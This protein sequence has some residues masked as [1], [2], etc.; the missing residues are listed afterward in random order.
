MDR[1]EGAVVEARER[2][3]GARPLHAPPR[4]GP[5]GIEAQEPVV[6]L[7]RLY[8]KAIWSLPSRNTAE[9]VSLP[10]PAIVAFG[11]VTTS[12]RLGA[13]PSVP[14]QTPDEPTVSDVQKGK[15]V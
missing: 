12:E 14:T 7:Q 1:Q 2:C 3:R 13:A 10:A 4:K 9:N 5:L 15:I 8:W 6:V 11:H